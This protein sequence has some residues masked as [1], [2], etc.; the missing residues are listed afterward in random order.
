MKV[1]Y[2]VEEDIMEEA[3]DYVDDRDLDD[4]EKIQEATHEQSGNPK[5]TLEEEEEERLI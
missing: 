3:K 2:R 4:V 5:N 1:Y